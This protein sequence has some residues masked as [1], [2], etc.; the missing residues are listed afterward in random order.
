MENHFE[1]NLKKCGLISPTLTDKIFI[2][3]VQISK[4]ASFTYLGLIFAA[5]GMTLKP[6][7]Q[8]HSKKA[9]LQ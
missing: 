3:G 7:S 2:N 9:F 6:T 8:R 1:F 4:V 5:K